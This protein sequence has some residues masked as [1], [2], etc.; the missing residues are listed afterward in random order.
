MDAAHGSRCGPNRYSATP[1]QRATAG[2]VFNG[3]ST[4]PIV[5]LTPSAV[6]MIPGDQEAVQ[7]A[8]GVAREASA[9]D[10][11]GRDELALGD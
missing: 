3:S 2:T 6:R 10:P 1:P 4:S 5:F 9:L 11:L 8:P 7:D